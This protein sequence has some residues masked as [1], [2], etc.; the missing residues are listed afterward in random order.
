MLQRMSDAALLTIVSAF[1]AIA[2]FALKCRRAMIA[3]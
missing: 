2:V 1:Y 3:H